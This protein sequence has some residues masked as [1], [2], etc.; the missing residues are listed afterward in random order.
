MRGQPGELG[1]G[2]FAGG[3]LHPGKHFARDRRPGEERGQR[4]ATFRRQGQRRRFGTNTPTRGS[5]GRHGKGQRQ[6]RRLVVVTR[7]ELRQLDDILGQRGD[8]GERI[9][10]L[11]RSPV[12]RRFA[13]DF[14]YHTSAAA[15][16]EA[17]VDNASA[18]D[19]K[20]IRHPIVE[21]GGDR[22]G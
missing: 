21:G 10:G 4:R 2:Q 16:G 8:F 20:T 22:D 9:D 13:N 1:C 17:D 12:R 15:A 6:S 11:Q 14:D 3:G 7:H 5:G 19:C 18:D